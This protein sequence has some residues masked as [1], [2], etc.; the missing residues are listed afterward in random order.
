MTVTWTLLAQDLRLLARE[1]TVVIV[2]A[3]ALAAVGYA[4]WSGSGWHARALAAQEAAQSALAAATA[5]EAAV[6]GALA[7]GTLPPPEAAAAGLP[8][9]VR[10]DYLRS[11]GPLA[12]LAIGDADLRPAQATIT[13]LGRADDLFR[14]YQVDNPA[15]LA[16]GRFD[17]AFVIVYL[18]PLLVLGMSYSVLSAD[19]ESGS[20]GLL[21]SQPLTAGRI[22][23]TRIALRT[24]IVAAAVVLG[25]LLAWWL[26]APRPLPAQAGA[27]M[28]LW[29]VVTLAWCAFWGGVAAFVAARNGSSDRNAL[30][31][32]LCWA[33]LTLLLPAAITL[34]AQTLSPTP[35]RLHY[36]TATRA[37]EN[38]AN[39]RGGELL[40]GY[41][42]DH[43]ELELTSESAV[44]PFIKTFVLVQQQVEAEVAPV[45]AR[46][47][48]QLARQ[49][50]I[51][52]TLA[53]LSPASLVQA[54]LTEAA[55]SGAARQQRFEAE[56]RALRRA[57]L[58]QLEGPLIAG[59]R[60]DAA[61]FRAL[62]RPAFAETPLPAATAATLPAALGLSG[63]ALLAL[64]A[65]QLRLRRFPVVAPD[66]A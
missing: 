57:W 14:A 30:A 48:E 24:G 25:G 10:T 9:T 38:A 40:Q 54:A 17:L 55:G 37:A 45:V 19:R 15:L 64:L 34:V 8:N 65:A 66:P 32:L 2:L 7:P 27:R 36:V 22:A 39:A 18:V 43:P 3:L 6:L 41:L 59:R 31:L 1:R 58:E 12:G 60:L 46:F 33:T 13:A 56:A 5:R 44:A 49:Q 62:P 51:A 63:Y 35:S 4:S 20:L 29:S 16:L 28:V 26:F 53:W 11:P 52:A 61:E 42:I 21:L 23:W 50:R 47:D